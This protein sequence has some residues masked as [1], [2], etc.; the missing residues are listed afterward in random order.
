MN[1]M[2]VILTCF[3]AGAFCADRLE[4]EEVFCARLCR[5][6]REPPD[7]LQMV[8]A[9]SCW[10]GRGAQGSVAS[11]APLCAAKAGALEALGQT[12]APRPSLLGCAK[13]SR[14][15]ARVAP[16]RT[17]PGGAHDRP[18]AARAGFGGC[19]SAPRPLRPPRAP[20]RVDHPLA[21]PS[22]L[23]GRFQGLVSHGRRPTPGAAHGAPSQKSLLAR[24]P[25]A[26]SAERCRRAPCPHPGLPPPRFAHRDPGGQRCALWRQGSPGAFAPE[27]L[28]A[29]PGDSRRVHTPG[30]PGRQRRARATAPLLQGRSARSSLRQS[31]RPAAPDRSLALR[32]QSSSPS[33]SPRS[34]TSGPTLSRFGPA[35][36]SDSDHLALSQK[37]G[38]TTRPSSWRHQMEWS[39][40]LCRTCFRRSNARSQKTHS[41]LLGD[42]S[43]PTFDWRVAHQRCRRHATRA[44][45]TPPASSS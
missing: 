12:S 6:R 31:P 1:V 16:L 26:P 19:L 33:R 29:A 44:L 32:L 13:N 7:W 35:C 25:A 18:L 11:A 8:A 40:A 37:L 28:V 36:A 34:K 17:A 20:S 10:W 27:R 15:P 23:D 42:S 3:G 2:E 30:T 21:T 22:S 41:I 14:P 39:S 38:P 5:T 24:D 43:R 45:A 4:F 9:L